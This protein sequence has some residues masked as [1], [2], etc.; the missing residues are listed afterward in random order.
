MEKPIQ[1]KRNF[2]FETV[3]YVLLGKLF[4]FSDLFIEG[5]YICLKRIKL[6][7]VDIRSFLIF[8][9]YYNN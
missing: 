3:E 4:F 8:V 5:Q 9:Y 2:I 7:D 6:H 1:K